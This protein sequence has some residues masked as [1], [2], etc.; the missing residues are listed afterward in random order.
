[1]E[2]S[3]KAKASIANG[4]KGG[5]K[6]TQGKEI[7]KNNS[8]K[9]GIL[10]LGSNSEDPVSL[11]QIYDQFHQEF[12]PETPSHEVLVQQLAITVARLSRCLRYEGEIVKGQTI[13]PWEKPILLERLAMLSERYESRLVSRM[14]RLINVLREK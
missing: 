12:K 10:S 3:K 14:L 5:V 7:S 9:H 4:K 8:L 2:L 13:F 11:E 1:M 6:T